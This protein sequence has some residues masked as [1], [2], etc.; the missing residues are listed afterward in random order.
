MRRRSDVGRINVDVRRALND[1][2]SGANI[3]LQ[4]NDSIDIPE[5]EPAVKVS[6]AVNSPGS[7]LWK[8][9]GDLEYYLE[10]AGGFSYRADKGKVSVK[11]A[12]GEVRTRRKNIFGTHD[13]RPGPGSEVFVPVKDTTDKVNYVALVRAVAQILASTAAIVVVLRR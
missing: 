6:G 3:I 1:T 10:G 2:A 8:K 9:T 12:N 4:P 7:V 5:Y 11:Y 13:P